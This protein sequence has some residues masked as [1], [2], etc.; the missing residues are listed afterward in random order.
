MFFKPFSYTPQKKPQ[1]ILFLSFLL[2]S[3]AEIF[4]SPFLKCEDSNKIQE[5]NKVCA[6]L[7]IVRGLFHNS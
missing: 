1:E 7:N 6:L 3:P 2:S 4:S 5:S